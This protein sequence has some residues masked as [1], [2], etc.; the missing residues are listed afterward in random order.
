MNSLKEKIQKHLKD[1][2]FLL[3]EMSLGFYDEYWENIY[4]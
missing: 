2:E 3:E 1:F 4:D